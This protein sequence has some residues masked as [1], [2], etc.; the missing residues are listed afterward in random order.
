MKYT[1]SITAWYLHTNR[2]SQL[3]NQKELGSSAPPFEVTSSDE[4]LKAD[5]AQ[6]RMKRLLEEW[7]HH[8]NIPSLGF[9][10][11]KNKKIAP[12]THFTIYHDFYGKGL[13]KYANLPELPRTAVAELHTTLK[14]DQ[15]MRLRIL[16]HP[17]NLTCQTAWSRLMRHMRVFAFCYLQSNNN[18][19]LIARP[20]IIGDLHRDISHEAPN[21]WFANDYGEIH[22]SMIDQFS[23]IQETLETESHAPSIA[24]LKEI[25]ESRIKR[26]FADILHES[27]L[28]NDWGGEK[29]DLFSPNLS[30]DGNPV[31]AAF[32]FKGPSKFSPMTIA[33]LGK[34]GDQIDRLF[35]EPAD[36]LVLQHCHKVTPPVRNMMRNYATQIHNLRHFCIID[37]YDTLRI[38][39]A[40]TQIL[41]D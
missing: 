8:N 32:L 22:P 36:V 7:L 16:Y 27:D 39:A 26:A 29:S 37:G 18:N 35:S 21:H 23:K 10:V 38:L 41:K 13:L 40:Y 6:A 5:I 28:P 17:A 31:S 25:S 20:Y 33:H 12:G 24:P 19:E 15:P 14:Y 2:I 34:N 9:L 3:L 4:S 1:T 11:E 30:I